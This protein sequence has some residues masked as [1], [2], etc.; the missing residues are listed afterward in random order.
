[1]PHYPVTSIKADDLDEEMLARKQAN[2]R[3]AVCLLMVARMQSTVILLRVRTHQ[4]FNQ[5][6]NYEIMDYANSV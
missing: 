3:L 1:M 6:G 4:P 2:H 5:T